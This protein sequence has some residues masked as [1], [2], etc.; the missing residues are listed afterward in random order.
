MK[1][2]KAPSHQLTIDQ[3][4]E[5]YSIQTRKYQKKDP[6]IFKIAQESK[7]IST[8]YLKCQIADPML[9][10]STKEERIELTKVGNR[11]TRI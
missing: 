6:K 7:N 2:V 5:R 4:C 9:H 3:E 8:Q 1:C 11:L 10:E